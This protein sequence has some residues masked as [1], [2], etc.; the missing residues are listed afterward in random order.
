MQRRAPKGYSFP[1]LAYA[2]LGG[3][4]A[5]PRAWRAAEPKP[6]Y[7]FIIV[8]GGGHGLA[9]AYYLARNHGARSVAVL[10]KSWIGGGNAGRNTAIVRSNY[11]LPANQAFYDFSLKLWEG[12]SQELNFNIMFSQR[13]VLFLG[14]SDGEMNRLAERGDA[15][16]FAGINAELLDRA[17]VAREAPLL[18]CSDKARFPVHGGLIQRRAGVARHDAVAWGYARA[19]DAL[20]IDIIQNCAVTGFDVA[21]GK[22]RGVRTSRGDIAAAHVGLAVA[23]RSSEVVAF[24]GLKLPIESHLLQAFV[25]EP[26]KPMLHNVVL[27]G[28]VHCYV[29]QTDKGEIVV[30]GDLDFYPSYSQRGSPA[31]I[32]EVAGQAIAMFPALGR[33]RMQRCWA[34]CVDMSM[35]GSPIIGATEIEGLYLNGGWCYGGFKAT[36]VSGWTFAH[37]L[38]TGAP[39]PLNAPF[40]LERFARGALIDEAGT[41]PVPHLH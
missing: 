2:A 33:L 37:T 23:G 35:D 31:R 40:A 29:S 6:A 4:R 18:D 8:G 1:A 11:R 7:D 39:H 3:H 32:M 30:G 17:D 16:R 21:G 36:P 12:L 28:A 14:H 15:M 10:E 24:A 5:W 34:G 19:A 9:T 22:V 26:I 38:A 27:S 13:G 20:G 41:G 25:S